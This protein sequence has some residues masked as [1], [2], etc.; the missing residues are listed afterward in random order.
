LEQA[1]A[2]ATTPDHRE[3]LRLVLTRVALIVVPPDAPVIDRALRICV[4]RVVQRGARGGGLVG[5]LIPLDTVTDALGA[6][7]G[8]DTGC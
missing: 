2:D 3:E 7:D 1:I 4:D 6:N 5:W 8:L